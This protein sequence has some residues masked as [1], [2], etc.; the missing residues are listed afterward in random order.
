M[1]RILIKTFFECKGYSILGLEIEEMARRMRVAIEGE[2][3]EEE[4]VVVVVE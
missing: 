2:E 4:E 1:K 3:E